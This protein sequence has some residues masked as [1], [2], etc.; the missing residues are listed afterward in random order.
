MGLRDGI[1]P[2]GMDLDP[3]HVADDE[4]RQVLQVQRIGLHL[5]QRGLQILVLALVFPGEAALAP[6]IGPAVAAARL[7]R[8]QA[9]GLAERIGFGR[10]LLADQ[11]AKVDE[12][13]LRRLPLAQ[14]RVAPLPDEIRRLHVRPDFPELTMP[15][16]ARANQRRAS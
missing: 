10:R 13:L 2:V 7:L 4:V 11:V 14:R 12:V 16:E 6:D 1:G 3:L 9:I 5:P 15:Y 8:A